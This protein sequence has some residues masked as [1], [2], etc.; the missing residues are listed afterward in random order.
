MSERGI[1]VSGRVAASSVTEPV[2]KASETKL[3]LEDLARA[4]G[5]E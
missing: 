2:D 3:D 1:R 4:K 5:L